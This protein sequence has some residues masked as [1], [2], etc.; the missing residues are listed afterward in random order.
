MHE[1]RR[2]PPAPAASTTGK[3]KPSYWNGEGVT[4]APSI[5]IVISEQRAYFYKGGKSCRGIDDF[6]RE[7]GIRDAAGEYKV[8][9]KDRDHVS[10][11]YGDYV[12]ED[13]DVVQRNVDAIKD[14]VPDGATFR[15]AKMPFF[16]RF[17][18]GYG[19]HA[20]YLPGYGPRMAACGCRW[21]WRSISS[22]RR[23]WGRR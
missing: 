23:W 21:R 8:I 12:D 20:G 3:G 2:P 6:Q 4:G 22:T 10:N 17:T 16:L 19:M 5:K 18:G 11:M 9:Q 15:G 14:P 1:C 7:E 13:G